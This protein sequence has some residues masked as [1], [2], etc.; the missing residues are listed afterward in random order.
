MTTVLHVV[1]LI[2]AGHLLTAEPVNRHRFDGTLKADTMPEI[3]YFSPQEPD[4]R[5][6]MKPPIAVPVNSKTGRFTV[7]LEEGIQYRVASHPP[8]AVVSDMI[9]D[10]ARQISVT[11]GSAGEQI[12]EL[13]GVLSSRLQIQGGYTSKD[14]FS[15]AFNIGG[16][17]G[18]FLP[19]AIVLSRLLPPL[20]A[21]TLAGGIR[22]VSKPC[23]SH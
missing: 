7:D 19:T 12:T 16:P 22:L 11:T 17:Q 1:L 10:N 23:Q 21:L 3:L 8:C 18:K 14:G 6:P 15:F 9:L 5:S 2:L 13:P 4:G 20:A